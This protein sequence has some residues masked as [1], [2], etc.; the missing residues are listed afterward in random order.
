MT[1]PEAEV[2]ATITDRF[3]PVQVNTQIEESKGVIERYHQAWTPDIRILAPDG[4]ELY[5]CQGYLPPF[6]FIPQLLTGEGTARFRLN[7]LA[8]AAACYDEVLRRF[9]TSA[10]APEAMY[11]RAAARYK[12]SHEPE[13]LLGGWRQLQSR[14]PDSIWRQ[15]QV[16]TEGE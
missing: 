14:Y 4:S 10:V 1:Y 9:P 16:F 8:G 5:A 15:K 12:A 6:E 13:D 2:A 7:D 3:V 11:F